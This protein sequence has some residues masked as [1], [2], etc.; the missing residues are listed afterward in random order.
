LTLPSDHPRHLIPALCRLFYTLKW[1]TGTGG[2]ISIKYGDEYY[3]APSGVQ[4]ERI[5]AEDLFVLK[6]VDSSS[7]S[8]SSYP[9]FPLVP[10]LSL[11]TV[12][13][14]PPQKSF[15]PSQCTPLF[16]SAF[17][18]RSALA[19]IHTHSQAAVLVTLMCK[20]EFR[21][22]H[23]EMIKGI[24]IGSTKNNFQYYD[25]LIVP[26]IENTPHEK[27]LTESL[28][29]ALVDY[30]ETNAVLVRRHGV[31]VWGESWEKAKTMTECYDYLF[32]IAIE[33]KTKLNINPEEVPQ[34]I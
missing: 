27:D 18:S 31:Y 29:Q 16:F 26:I 7:S 20:K 12:S 17:K 3:V 9:P 21:I 23:Q 32:E 1:V 5:E 13:S 8:S 22:T 19:C 10:F 15:T 30:P 33:M 25:L 24:R 34:K 4:K 2:G 28:Q 6:E 11:Y 14:P